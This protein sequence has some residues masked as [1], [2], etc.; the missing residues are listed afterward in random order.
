[1]PLPFRLD[2]AAG[3]GSAATEFC[4]T[5]ITSHGPP[6]IAT[7]NIVRANPHIHLGDSA[8][9]GYVLLDVTAERCTARMQVLDD[10]TDRHTQVR[11]AAT[12]TVDAG[13]PGAKRVNG[14]T[15]GDDY[16]DCLRALGGH[17]P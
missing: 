6:Q 5:S 1:M 2:P 15:S 9:R 12:F 4:A 8:H 17:S 11:T 16:R 3:H 10:P 13:Q 7:D 14:P